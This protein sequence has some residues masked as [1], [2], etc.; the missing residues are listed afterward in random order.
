MN[1][2]LGSEAIPHSGTGPFE[3][4]RKRLADHLRID[5]FDVA[6]NT[7]SVGEARRRFGRSEY[8]GLR[9]VALETVSG[10]IHSCRSSASGHRLARN[11]RVVTW[12]S[13]NA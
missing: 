9:S 3:A 10:C 11:H 6:S 4:K 2:Y 8:N 1:A 5:A 7:A 13:R 12:A